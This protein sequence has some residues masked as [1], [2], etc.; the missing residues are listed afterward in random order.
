MSVEVLQLTPLIKSG[1]DELHKNYRVC[2]WYDLLDREAWLDRNGGS[3]RAVVTA[4]HL[5]ITN[6]MMQRLPSLGMVAIAGV[7][8]ERVDLEEASA[9][10]IRVSNTPKILTNDVADLAIGLM[11]ATMRRIPAADRH[12]RDGHWT[13]SE[14]PLT[15]KVSGRR[16][17]IYGLGQIGRAVAQRLQGFGGTIA[18]TSTAPKDVPYA[19][20]P[21]LLELAKASDVLFLTVAASSATRNIVAQ[22][23]FDALGPTGVLVNV[24]RGLIVHEQD[25]ITALEEG[26]LGGAGLDVYADEP[27]VPAALAA[28]PNTV[29]TPHV[30]SAT[31]DARES[32]AQLMLANLAAFFS[33]R[34][35]PTPV[36]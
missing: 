13:S 20:H 11:I 24:A 12:L 21:T 17:G 2:R 31:V 3:I 33:E 30:G 8:Y 6:E 7:G 9:R 16:Y 28:L 29:L 5:G 14:M 18:Y 19:F 26:R 35:L 22:K 1:D 27:N 25:L 15:N 23:I 4:G 10:K 34:P 32:M 36:L